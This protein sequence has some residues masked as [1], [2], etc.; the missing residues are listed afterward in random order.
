MDTGTSLLFSVFFGAIGY[1]YFIYGKRQQKI[2]PMIAGISL[3]VYPYFVSNLL[4]MIV[5][6]FILIAIPMLLKL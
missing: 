4:I 1:G 3:C 6:G 2:V 5:V